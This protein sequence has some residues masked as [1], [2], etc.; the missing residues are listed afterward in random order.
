MGIA[1]S[2]PRAPSI[3]GHW[4]GDLVTEAHNQSAI[5]TLV[6][7]TTR[8]VMLV[9]LPVDHNESVRNGLFKTMVTLPDRLRGSLT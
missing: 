6:E 4:V 2:T 7:R 9:H 1:R 5:A 8:Y 3:P